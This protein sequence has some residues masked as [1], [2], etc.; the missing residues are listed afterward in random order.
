M[1][2]I[3]F[4]LESG[5]QP[6][7]KAHPDDAGWDVY[8]RD[9]GEMVYDGGGELMFIRYDTGVKCDPGGAFLLLFPRSSVCK[10]DLIMANSVG[11][12]DPGYRGNIIAVFRVVGD[13]KMPDQIKRYKKGDRVAQLVPMMPVLAE[14]Q[15]N[16]ISTSGRGTGGFG[17][18]GS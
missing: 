10:T 13:S 14:F 11:L 12:I 15:E 2:V 3:N 1:T 18:T 5:A 7:R 17:S 8:A 6:P 9:D 16:S 4:E